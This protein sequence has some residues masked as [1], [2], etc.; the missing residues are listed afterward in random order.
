M[1]WASDFHDRAMEARG[2][3]LWAFAALIKM[4]F[5]DQTPFYDSTT[6]DQIIFE[7]DWLRFEDVKIW[8]YDTGFLIY[9][10]V[11]PNCATY[12]LTNELPIQYETTKGQSWVFCLWSLWMVLKPTGKPWKWMSGM[13]EWT[14]KWELWWCKVV[15]WIIGG[16]LFCLLLLLLL[17]LSLLLLL[18][19]VVVLF[20]VGKFTLVL[21]TKLALV[22]SNL[23]LNFSVFQ[24]MNYNHESIILGYGM[25]SGISA[26]NKFTIHNPG[27]GM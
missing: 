9:L 3:G 11:F 15:H 6:I 27:W 25:L 14:L 26:W 17:L 10:C 13:S 7:L 1:S 22:W 16:W 12:Q 2:L 5:L 21:L 4:W 8:R 20:D 24:I 18:L 23:Y 19:V